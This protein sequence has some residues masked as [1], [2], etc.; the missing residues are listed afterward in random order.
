MIDC[1]VKEGDDR[2]KQQLVTNIRVLLESAKGAIKR[3]DSFAIL[4]GP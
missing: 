2:L 3:H 4:K 1:W